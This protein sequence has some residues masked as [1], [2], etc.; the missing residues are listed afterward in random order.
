MRRHR[1]SSYLGGSARP[2]ERSPAAGRGSLPR[3]RDRRVPAARRLRRAAAGR[4]ARAPAAAGGSGRARSHRCRSDGDSG[5]PRDRWQDRQG[6][7]ERDAG[8]MGA[9]VSSSRSRATR[10][11]LSRASTARIGAENNGPTGPLAGRA[12]NPRAGLTTASLP[13]T[14][15]RDSADRLS[16]SRMRRR[17]P[18]QGR[19]SAR[20][21]RDRGRGASGA[22]G[23]GQAR[24]LTDSGSDRAGSHL[25][26]SF[27]PERRAVPVNRAPPGRSEPRPIGAWERDFLV[28]GHVASGL[29]PPESVT[30]GLRG[31]AR[32][33]PGP[34]GTTR[35]SPT[36]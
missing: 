18:P 9:G 19:R 32:R 16:S 35:G 31:Q 29:G 4:R 6:R 3:A 23:R 14:S 13:D 25:G 21:R 11:P 33:R 34:S 12:R 17:A 28:L 22:A 2:R 5:P 15:T 36:G 24:I 20:G 26:Q 10:L 7:A 8:M 27:C 1:R 30:P